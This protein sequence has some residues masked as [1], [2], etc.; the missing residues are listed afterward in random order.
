MNVGHDTYYAHVHGTHTLV[1]VYFC[2][3]PRGS[4]SYRDMEEILQG[5]VQPD[6]A[7]TPHRH[8]Y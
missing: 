4:L 5:I 8:I 3:V 2:N 1:S 6:H 7:L